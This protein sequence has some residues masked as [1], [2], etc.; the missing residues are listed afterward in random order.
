MISAAPD[1]GTLSREAGA[2]SYIEKPF[3]IKELLKVVN[4]YTSPQ[5]P[6]PRRGA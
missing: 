4:F 6:V 2:D 1:I 3:E 5:T